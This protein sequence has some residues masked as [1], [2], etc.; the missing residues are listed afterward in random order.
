MKKGSNVKIHGLQ[1]EEG[2]KLNGVEGTIDHYSKERERYA[3]RVPGCGSDLKMI[4]EDNLKVVPKLG[5]FAGED[6]MME[7]LKQMG[8]PESMLRDLTP[9]KKKQMFEMTQRQDIIER[10]KKAV[11]VTESE[12]PMKDDPSGVFSWRDA[13]DHVYVEIKSADITE[14]KKVSCDITP[15]S[16]CI[17]NGDKV[18]LEGN[19][20]QTVI[21]KESEWAVMDGKI[22]MTLKKLSIMRWLMLTR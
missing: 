12:T 13:S 4:K 9:E 2:Q 18:I 5:V 1:S 6:E 10:A 16:L 21:P 20:F 3:I 11:G 8:M 19:L 7:R 17:K 22:V 14:E 15:K